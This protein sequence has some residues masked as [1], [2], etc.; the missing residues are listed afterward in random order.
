M[1]FAYTDS[2]ARYVSAAL[3]TFS[4]IIVLGTAAF[5]QALAPSLNQGLPPPD[6]KAT[7]SLSAALAE[8]DRSAGTV[9]A[10]VGGQAVTWGDV[11]DAIR[12]MPPIVSAIPFQQLYQNATVQ[13]MEQKALVRLGDTTGLNKDPVV[14]RRM[15]NAAEQLMATEVLRRSLAPNITDKALRAVYD[16]V[17]AGKPGPDEVRARIIMTETKQEAVVLIQKL[18]AGE[19]FGTLA[20]KFSKD[21]TASKGG[22]LGYARLDMLAP[23]IGAVMFSFGVGQ[24]T[25]YPV[26][27]GNSWF[28]VKVEGRRQPP[29]PSFEE[30]RPALERDI[31]HAGVPELMRMAL[32]PMDV[33]YHGLAGQKE[34]DTAPK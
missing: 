6:I 28:I 11:A 24:T 18:Q 19:D 8:L 25:A 32:Q 17:I 20:Q 5:A 13:V 27:S 22:D 26:R 7:A 2:M 15:K 34:T 3:A 9:V 23:E 29:A 16:G 14:Q 4:L 33:K 21:G 10:E 30:A 12:A 1:P 31:I